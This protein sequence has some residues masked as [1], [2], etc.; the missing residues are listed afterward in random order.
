MATEDADGRRTG[1]LTRSARMDR[2]AALTELLLCLPVFFAALAALVRFTQGQALSMPA[3]EGA[4]LGAWA[5]AREGAVPPEDLLARAAHA[6]SETHWTVGTSEDTPGDWTARQ[7]APRRGAVFA[8]DLA[9]SGRVTVTVRL[10]E[11]SRNVPRV[12]E[13]GSAA[14]QVTLIVGD[15]RPTQAGWCRALG[16]GPARFWDA[17][18]GDAGDGE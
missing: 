17:A 16:G 1:F 10:R 9:G 8:A 15:G 11:R 13:T 3:H 14:S 4:R 6:P 7:I 18:Q 2:G 5:R 12:F